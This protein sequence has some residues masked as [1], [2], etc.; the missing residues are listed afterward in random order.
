MTTDTDTLSK[1]RLTRIE[2]PAGNTSLRLRDVWE[3]RELLYFLTW[4]DV[5]VRYKQTALG[6][7]WAALQP[8]LTLGIFVLV[9]SRAAAL[10]S[11]G[12][13]YVEFALAGL[14]PWALVSSGL[15]QCANSVVSGAGLLTKVW[16]PRLVMP[17]ASVL[18]AV[19]D[20]LIAM[21]LLVIFLVLSG[22]TPDMVILWL[23][24]AFVMLLAS[25]LGLGL[26]L[27]AANVRYRDIRYA[28]PFLTQ[29]WLFGTPIAYPRSALGPPW[30]AVLVFNPLT[31]AVETFRHAVLGTPIDGAEAAISAVVAVVLLLSGAVYFRRMERTFADI[32]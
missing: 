11:Q 14:V 7:L 1:P 9:F 29:L 32:V 25:V 17:I 27:A 26:W 3:H 12:V 23:V 16:F 24:P 5:K 30:D 19:I 28:V 21:V 22:K 6:V 13:P 18:G 10:P 20:L 8:L 2:P 31:G 4:R 15:P